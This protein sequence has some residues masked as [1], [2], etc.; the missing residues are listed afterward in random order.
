MVGLN[1]LHLCAWHLIHIIIY[2]TNLQTKRKVVSEP[3]WVPGIIATIHRR[4]RLP[5]QIISTIF[6]YGSLIRTTTLAYAILGSVLWYLISSLKTLTSIK[7]T[8]RLDT[9]VCCFS[10]LWYCLCLNVWKQSQQSTG[11]EV[12]SYVFSLSSVM[13]GAI[14]L[15]DILMDL[16]EFD[17]VASLNALT[18]VAHYYTLIFQIRVN[19]I[20]YLVLALQPMSAVYGYLYFSLHFAVVSFGMVLIIFVCLA[21]VWNLLIVKTLQYSKVLVPTPGTQKPIP[22]SKDYLLFYRIISL[23]HCFMFITMMIPAII[24]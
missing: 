14:L 4:T 13:V 15:M 24:I 21:K 22:D 3:E 7:N 6:L 16:T 11:I 18:R 20:A 5:F 2:R 10:F 8:I 19:Y 17:R 1:P 12:V 9:I 23:L